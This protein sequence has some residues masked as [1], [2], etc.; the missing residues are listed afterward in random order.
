[1]LLEGITEDENNL[2]TNPPG[3]LDEDEDGE[4]L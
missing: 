1:M 3:F 2:L 4:V